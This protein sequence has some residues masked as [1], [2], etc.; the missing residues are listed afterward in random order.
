MN[1]PG[2]AGEST[3]LLVVDRYNDFLSEGGKLWPRTKA[4]A[5]RVGLLGHMRQVLAAARASRMRIFFVPHRRTSPG[6]YDTW[7]YLS[8][9]QD[10]TRKGQV[11][12]AGTWGGEFHPATSP[13]GRIRRSSPPW[14]P[15]HLHVRPPGDHPARN[16]RST[17]GR[18][19]R[20]DNGL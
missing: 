2:Y 1:D 14:M 3:A 5:E 8:P 6:D 7:A 17:A 13:C 10:A 15:G 18:T 20:Y 4:A 19:T 11:F 12:A 16:P 9:S